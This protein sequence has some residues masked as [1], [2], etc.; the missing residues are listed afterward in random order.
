M[1]SLTWWRD[2]LWTALTAVEGL[3]F[4]Y[5]RTPGP[6]WAGT[7]VASSLWLAS[8]PEIFWKLQPL[9]LSLS[10]QVKILISDPLHL[11]QGIL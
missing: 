11:V 2:W 9:T 8:L 3:G 6:G 1:E 4:C 7:A 10:L 5:V